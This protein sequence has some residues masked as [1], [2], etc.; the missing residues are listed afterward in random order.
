MRYPTP[1]RIF[2]VAVV[3]AAIVI[4]VGYRASAPPQLAADSVRA[5]EVTRNIPA[6]LGVAFGLPSVLDF[7]RDTCIPCKEMKPILLGLQKAYKGN[8]DIRIINID[9]EPAATEAAGIRL[10]PTQ[11][12]FNSKGKEVS[13]HEGFMPRADI[14]AQLRKMGVK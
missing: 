3:T 6:S 10:I 11:I 9:E 8:A 14:V 13:R 12:F 2:A 4:F 7:G 5:A 1:V